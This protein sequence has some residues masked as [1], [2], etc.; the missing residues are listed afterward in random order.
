MSNTCVWCYIV[1]I[2][3]LT[4]RPYV[5]GQHPIPEHSHR[6]RWLHRTLQRIQ[7][8]REDGYHLLADRYTRALQN[9]MTILFIVKEPNMPPQYIIIE[10]GAPNGLSLRPV[11]PLVQLNHARVSSKHEHERNTPNSVQPRG[12]TEF[13]GGRACTPW[14]TDRMVHGVVKRSKRTC[15]FL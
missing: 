15:S 5:Y 2:S 4:S 11:I 3:D 6:V 13:G 1:I 8:V 9:G 10:T 14:D 7:I 12:F